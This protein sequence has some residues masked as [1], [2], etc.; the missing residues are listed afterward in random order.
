MFLAQR[1]VLALQLQLLA[2]HLTDLLQADGTL[3]AL[4][5]EDEAEASGALPQRSVQTLAVV[6]SLGMASSCI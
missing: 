5:E 6:A 1:Q 3:A 4:D 2:R